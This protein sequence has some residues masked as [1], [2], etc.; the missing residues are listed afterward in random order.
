MKNLILILVFLFVAG[1][2]T[3]K[4]YVGDTVPDSELAIIYGPKNKLFSAKKPAAYIMAVNGMEVGNVVKGY[5][6]YIKVKPGI[7]E[8]KLN[9]IWPS[10]ARGFASATGNVVAMEETG[11]ASET[12]KIF[13]VEVEKGNSYKIEFE[14][15][16]GVR[17]IAPN[18]SVVNDF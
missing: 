18:V 4:G 5:P 14:V 6:K 3:T 17:D 15:V 12:I 8:L 2:A 16:D 9:L 7:V 11:V 10:L 13:K 1:C